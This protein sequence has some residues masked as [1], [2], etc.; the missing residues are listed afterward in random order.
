LR[1]LWPQ[2]VL[3]RRGTSESGIN[4]FGILLTDCWHFSSTRGLDS[5]TALEFVRALRIA[6]DL[7]KNSTIVSIYQAGESLFDIFDKVCLI[8]EGRMVYYGPASMARQ[9]FIN[10]GYV[11]AD[12][13]TTPDFLVAVTDPLGRTA[14]MEEQRSIE[15]KGRPIPQT[16]AEFEDY[17]RKSKMRTTNLEDIES[18]KTGNVDKHDKVVAYKESARGEHA[19]HTRPKVRSLTTRD[20]YLNSCLPCRAH[21]RSRFRCK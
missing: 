17:Y 15:S 8:Y 10:M 5:S 16:P 19:K 13:Q 21:T 7:A 18:Y 1:R 4:S 11:P 3:S 2:G 14:A 12:R 9:Y 6:T 20:S